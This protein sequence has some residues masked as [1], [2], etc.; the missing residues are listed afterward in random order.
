MADAVGWRVFQADWSKL[1]LWSPLRCLPAI[2][3]VLAVGIVTGYSRASVAMAAGAYSV[4]FGSFHKLRG[5]RVLPMPLAALGMGIASWAGTLAG[6]SA[7]AAVYMAGLAAFLYAWISQYDSEASWVALQAAI[8]LVIS[9]G[10]PER[11]LESLVRGGLVLAGGLLQTALIV[12]WWRLEKAIAPKALNLRFQ[13]ATQAAAQPASDDFPRWLF[14]LRAAL[15]MAVAAAL[16]KWLSKQNGYW[17]PMTTLIVIRREF[18]DATQRGLARVAGTITGAAVAS[19]I[20]YI[21]PSS[22]WIRAAGV[23]LFAWGCYALF[24]VSYAHFATCL[25]A[26]LAFLF[27]LAGLE[28]EGVIVRRVVFTAMGGALAFLM[29]WIAER[30]VRKHRRA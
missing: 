5:S 15:T 14:P 8:W 11:G 26:Y 10:Y 17:L 25:T 21:A 7:P 27:S 6:L 30:I 29:H 13:G 1:D 3:L 19:L 2:A 20:V 9:T 28:G 23:V 4:G 12:L 22:P 16:Y 18:H 24:W